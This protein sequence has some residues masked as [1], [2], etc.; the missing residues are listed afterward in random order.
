MEAVSPAT[1]LFFVGVIAFGT[2]VMLNLFL[3]ILLDNFSAGD[4]GSASGGT[5]S[6]TMR[7]AAAAAAAGAA[8]LDWMRGLMG[9]SWLAARRRRQ[10]VAPL[11]SPPPLPQPQPQAQAQLQ[12][13]PETQPERQPQLQSQQQRQLPEQPQPQP[14]LLPQ[15]QLAVR[16]GAC[17]QVLL[18]GSPQVA[19]ETPISRASVRLAPLALPAASRTVAGSPQPAEAVAHSDGSFASLS[20]QRLTTGPAVLMRGAGASGRSSPVGG[21]LGG[22]PRAPSS[23]A[24]AGLSPADGG[25]GRWALSCAT[26]LLGCCG[27][28]LLLN[29]TA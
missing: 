11:P 12:S 24:G 23:L 27:A 5:G 13:H 25:F 7:E 3:A 6:D 28:A 15:P 9:C 20:R 29:P 14:Q 4:D 8:V 19:T 22:S 17:A 10:R 26:G 16:R 1:C 2:Y 18:T 21:A